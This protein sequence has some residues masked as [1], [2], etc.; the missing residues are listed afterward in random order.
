MKDKSKAETKKIQK[1]A[2]HKE[3]TDI[4]KYIAKHN[5][6]RAGKLHELSKHKKAPRKE[7]DKDIIYNEKRINR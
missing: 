4:K 7:L 2:K 5:I 1:E 3:R 6:V